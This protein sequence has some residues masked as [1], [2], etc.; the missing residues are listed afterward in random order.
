D[1]A[2][3]DKVSSPSAICFFFLDLVTLAADLILL[4]EE[5]LDS[6]IDKN[7]TVLL[8]DFILRDEFHCSGNRVI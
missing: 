7:G 5:A 6:F 8:N 4:P 2:I 1:K 3:S